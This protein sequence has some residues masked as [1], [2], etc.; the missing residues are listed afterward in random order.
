MITIEILRNIKHDGQQFHA[1][2]IRIVTD[3][4]GGYFCGNGWAREK[5]GE[6]MPA[7]TTPKTLSVKSVTHGHKAATA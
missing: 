7:D 3:Q 1:G 4:L 5:G 6:V 2:E